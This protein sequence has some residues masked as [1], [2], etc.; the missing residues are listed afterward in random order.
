M[1]KVRDYNYH[2]VMWAPTDQRRGLERYHLLSLL[3]MWLTA[4]ESETRISTS[5]RSALLPKPCSVS[6]INEV[7]DG[8]GHD[9][10]YRRTFFDEVKIL[11]G[12]TLPVFGCAS[13]F[14]FML[15]STSYLH[16]EH[17]YWRYHYEPFN[18]TSLV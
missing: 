11:A 9:S 16:T 1:G 13:H 2:D 3:T 7:H 5:E 4:D 17:I 15:G 10:D 8:P 18:S 6:P 12:Y 14:Y